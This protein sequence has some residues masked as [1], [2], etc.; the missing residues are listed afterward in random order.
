MNFSLVTKAG[1]V[2]DAAPSGDMGA[3]ELELP[4][5]WDSQKRWPTGSLSAYFEVLDANGAL[6]PAGTL[7]AQLWLKDNAT[8]RWIKVGA[9][10]TAV[11]VDVL[12]EW[13]T[14]GINTDCKAFLQL[15]TITG[16]GAASVK[17]FVAPTGI[18]S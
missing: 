13:K 11:A 14:S 5:S 17:T 12:T 6:I 15:T 9:A 3:R 4:A 16:A 18:R 8:K 1:V 7:T 2:D 10:Q